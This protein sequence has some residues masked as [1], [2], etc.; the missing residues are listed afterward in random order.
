MREFYDIGSIEQAWPQRDRHKFHAR[1]RQPCSL[2]LLQAP[3]RPAE[4]RPRGNK[5]CP[6]FVRARIFIIAAM[7]AWIAAGNEMWSPRSRRFKTASRILPIMFRVLAVSKKRRRTFEII[8]A[9][10]KPNSLRLA[11]RRTYNA[12]K[13][14]APRTANARRRTKTS[15]L[16]GGASNP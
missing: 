9:I 7:R 2:I 10:R 13:A 6:V 3:R 4:S 11:L 5:Q 8:L 15:P 14:A 1:H 16:A 12:P